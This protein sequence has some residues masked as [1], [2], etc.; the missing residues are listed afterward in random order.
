MNRFARRLVPFIYAAS[1]VVF[2]SDLIGGD[3][4]AYGVIYT[5]LVATAVFHRSH[6]A[7]WWLT[8]VACA[9][10]VIGG[11][12]PTPD[13]QNVPELLGD[14]ALSIMAILSTA[15]FVHYGRAIQDRLSALT[16][17]ATAAERIK[18]DVLTDLTGEIRTPLHTLLGVLTLAMTACSRDQRD[19]MSR[20]RSDAERLLGTIDN[21]IDLL[22]IE[23]DT[24]R[25]QR[26]DML[27]IAQEA[28]DDAGP[29]ARKRQITLAA[30]GEEGA[31]RG[32]PRAT[33]R[34]LDKLLARSIWRTPPGGTV[35]IA[36]SRDAGVVT[37][38]V[39]HAG[40]EATPD[41]ASDPPRND[42]AINGGAPEVTDGSGLALICRLAQTMNGRVVAIADAGSGGTV[43]L[44]LPAA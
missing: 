14:G 44:T 36:V 29:A 5:P 1:A 43:S 25:P 34:I 42:W 41:A 8:A 11:F 4:L 40:T 27:S 38:S 22:Q 31:T 2:F 28:V 6:A 24:L 16:A 3:V 10:V 9:M 23:A 13:M 18:T 20:I 26:I 21:L 32:D 37:A 35:S 19:S 30:T 15:A 33:R 39:D 7:L 12:F 17:R